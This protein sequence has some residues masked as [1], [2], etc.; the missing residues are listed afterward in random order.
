MTIF[1]PP[2]RCNPWIG[3]D[4]VTVALRQRTKW[5]RRK[6][7]QFLRDK[8]NGIQYEHIGLHNNVHSSRQ[9]ASSADILFEHDLPDHFNFDAGKIAAAPPP[10]IQRR[11]MSDYRLLTEFATFAHGIFS[12]LIDDNEA[13]I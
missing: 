1:P 7:K 11:A 13:Y 3:W 9:N 10:L 6:R 2:S 4:P 8:N 5:M 12:F